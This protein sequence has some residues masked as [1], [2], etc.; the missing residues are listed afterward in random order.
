MGERGD[1]RR[2]DGRDVK[3]GRKGEY[4]DRASRRYRS[5]AL[6]STAVNAAGLARSRCARKIYNAVKA[7]LARAV[8]S[9]ANNSNGSRQSWT[10]LSRS[11]KNFLATTRNDILLYV[12]GPAGRAGRSYALTKINNR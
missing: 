2:W 5:S 8:D 10:S 11:V 3:K 12:T 4:R 7:R 6:A 1:F 9:T